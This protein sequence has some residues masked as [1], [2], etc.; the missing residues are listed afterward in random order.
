MARNRSAVLAGSWY[1][2]SATACRQQILDF[3]GPAPD[4]AVPE[5]PFVGGI[6]P[7]AGWFFSGQ[8]ACRV[9]ERLATGTAVDTVAIF[10]MHLHP[11][12]RN[13]LMADGA[14]DTPLGPLTVDAPLAEALRRRFD[15][16]IETADDSTPDNTI[17]VQLPFIKYFFPDTRIVPMGVPP[18]TASLEIGSAV[19]EE[20]RRL[21]REIRVIGSTDLT[22]YGANYGFSPQGRGSAALDWVRNDNDRRVIDA[23]VAMAPERVIEE[24]LTRHNACCS[25]SAATAVAAAKALGA[26]RGIELSYAT[27]YDK[28]PGDSFVGYVGILY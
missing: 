6:V 3:I 8:M 10:G 14:W 12:S 17:E 22:H 26:E 21:G 11:G 5:G 16:K 13:I 25:G 7:H 19:A 24:G 4:E 2:D 27:S 1:P 23:M 28:H 15:F 9:V 18:V 20:A